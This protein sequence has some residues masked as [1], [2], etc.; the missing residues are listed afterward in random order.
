[1]RRSMLGEP[2]VL[3]QHRLQTV[4]HSQPLHMVSMRQPCVQEIQYAKDE[5]TALKKTTDSWKSRKKQK[6]EGKKAQAAPKADEQ[7]ASA[8]AS[9]AAPTV[10]LRSACA[11]LVIHALLSIIWCILFPAERIG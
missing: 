3:R 8:A 11:I 7:A 2:S 1:M 5:S 10:L 4:S 6:T 9:A